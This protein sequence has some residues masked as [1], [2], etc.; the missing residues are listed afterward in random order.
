M[1]LFKVFLVLLLAMPA[2]GPRMP[3]SAMHALHDQHISHHEELHSDHNHHGHHHTNQTE[4]HHE[5]SFDVVTYFSDYLHVDL[6]AP[7]QHSVT[8]PTTNDSGDVIVTAEL[9]SNDGGI[10]P[11]S[12]F[13]PPPQ[14]Y[15]SSYNSPVYLVT[16]RIRI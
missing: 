1:N 14:Y 5:F 2:L 10:I 11:R 4:L 9:I 12:E 13:R 16:Q 6:K 3:H 7:S 8:A 15:T